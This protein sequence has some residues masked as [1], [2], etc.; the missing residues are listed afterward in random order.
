MGCQRVNRMSGSGSS[1]QTVKRNPWLFHKYYKWTDGWIGGMD[2]SNGACGPFHVKSPSPSLVS[3]VLILTAH[4]YYVQNPKT[5]LQECSPAPGHIY[6]AIYSLLITVVLLRIAYR[7]S[8]G[9][10]WELK[11]RNFYRF[12]IYRLFYQVKLRKLLG[13]MVSNHL[14]SATWF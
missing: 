8:I 9:Y 14:Y 7:T 12:V 2:T 5:F 4:P 10:Q 6:T 11:S 1:G 3:F 13:C